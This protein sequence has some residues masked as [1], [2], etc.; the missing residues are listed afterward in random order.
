MHPNRA[1]AWTDE[2]EMLQFIAERSF[3]TIFFGTADGPRVVHVPVTVEAGPHLQFH[4]ARSNRAAEGL[5][6]AEVLLSC[7]GPDAYVSPDWYGTPDQ[8]PT[9]NYVA[10]E[11]LGIARRLGDA[12]LAGQLDSLSGEHE[13]RLLPKTPWTRHKMKRGLFEGMMKAIICF[14]IEISE[15]RGTRKL[16]QNKK[17]DE[18]EGALAGLEAAGSAELATVMREEFARS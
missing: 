16:G 13:A 6:G 15:L 11:C 2:A 17:A 5:D 9:W 8:V 1:F 12:E 7:L 3:S 10:V 4:L 14:E 18:R